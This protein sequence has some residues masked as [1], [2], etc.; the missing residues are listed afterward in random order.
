MCVYLTSC[1]F[2]SSEYLILSGLGLPP[3]PSPASIMKLKR[4][5]KIADEQQKQYAKQ[6]HRKIRTG[7]LPSPALRIPVDSYVSFVKHLESS[8]RI[9]VRI[10][11]L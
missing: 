6:Q 11:D 10:F 5:S 7:I 4:P 8:S 3:R 1:G 2:K 9:L